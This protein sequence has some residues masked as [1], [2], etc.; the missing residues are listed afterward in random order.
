MVPL[1]DICKKITSGGTPARSHPEFYTGDIPWVKTG[2]LKSW[3]IRNTEEKITEEAIN[4]SSAKIYPIDTVLL[5]MYG[6]GRTIGSVGITGVEAASNQACC[7]LMTDPNK[8]DPLFLLYSLQHHRIEIVSLALGASQRNLNQGTIKNFKIRFPKIEEQR[9]ISFT[10]SQFDH[11]IEN[12]QRRIMI[13]E[14]MA[15]SLYREWFVYFRFPG[16]ENIRLIDSPL[17][18]IP[19]RW[20][21]KELGDLSDKITRGVSP[22][23]DPD[24]TDL[25]VNQKCI[26]N[27]K[28]SLNLARPHSSKVPE[29]KYL[30]QGDILINS[31]GVGTLG[32]LAQ[33]DLKNDKRITVD[34][35]ITI[36]RPND[37]VD[38]WFIGKSLMEIE[39]IIESMGE[40]ATGQTELNRDRL[41]KVQVL[42]PP[43]DLQFSFSQMV[44]PLNEMISNLSTA[45]E[46]LCKIK[47]LLL[48]KLI[49]GEFNVSGAAFK[50]KEAA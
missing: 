25:V 39:P 26:R 34:S 40:G 15:R 33:F 1:V 32:R 43:R 19:H 42:V 4:K 21:V 16:H 14:D 47:N 7:A 22:K 41:S 9:E 6:D 12:N 30:L 13:L 36:L 50:L 2:E 23:Y 44:V 29:H 11:L 38:T 5:A 35:H 46:Y 20:D 45:N 31:T 37:Q 18:P 10:L 48:P 24:S 8:C 27:H 49:S 3:Y 17:G 28:L